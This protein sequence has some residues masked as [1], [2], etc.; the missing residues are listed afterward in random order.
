M[1]TNV[2]FMKVN[3]VLFITCFSVCLSTFVFVIDMFV[4]KHGCVVF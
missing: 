1:A 3:F 2:S 4:S